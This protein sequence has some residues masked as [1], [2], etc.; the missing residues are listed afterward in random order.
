MNEEKYETLS[1]LRINK[2]MEG[3]SMMLL[4]ESLRCGS[5]IR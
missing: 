5:D 2:Y 4:H 1:D 3:G